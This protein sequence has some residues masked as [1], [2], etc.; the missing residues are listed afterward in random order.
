M[1]YLLMNIGKISLQFYNELHCILPMRPIYKIANATFVWYTKLGN[2]I[3]N[4]Y[5]VDAVMYVI[6]QRVLLY[7]TA[8]VRWGFYGAAFSP[9][10]LF[11]Y[12][13]YR[14]LDWNSIFVVQNRIHY[15]ISQSS[16]HTNKKMNPT[17]FSLDIISTTIYQI[18][19]LKLKYL[20]LA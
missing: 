10:N 18:I 15:S 6:T 13:T 3:L 16:P 2:Y 9:N 12:R 4:E 11:T 8:V 20:T 14:T 17:R 5:D 19:N 1:N 7:P